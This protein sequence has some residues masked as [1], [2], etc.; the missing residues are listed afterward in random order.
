MIRFEKKEVIGER[1]RRQRLLDPI[2]GL[3]DEQEYLDLFKLLQPV[4]PVHNTRPGDPPKLVHRT[5]F[6]DDLL[7]GKLRE[8]NTLIKGRFCGG[9]IGYVLQEDLEPYAIAFHK[10]ISNVNAIHEDILSILKHSG[11]LSKDQLKQE[12]GGYPASEISKALQTLQEAF[13]IYEHQPDTDGTPDGLILQRNGL[14]L[15]LMKAGIFNPFPRSSTHLYVRWYLQLPQTSKVG[16]NCPSNRYK[17]HSSFY[18][19]KEVF[20]RR[21][22]LNWKRICLHRR[23]KKS[24]CIEYSVLYLY[25]G[26]I[27]FSSE[28][29]YG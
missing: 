17:K 29:T 19:K 23:R 15:K 20:W 3:D 27:R 28:S 7:T 8:K 12:L 18:W 14:R 13:L 21:K 16:R 5:L 11:G 1:L 22:P 9:R 26:Q 25:A 6:H 4:S 2:E 24:P 10:P